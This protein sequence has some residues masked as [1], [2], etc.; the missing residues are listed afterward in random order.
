[1]KGL[2]DTRG[3]HLSGNLD[4][5]P[6]SL[7]VSQERTPYLISSTESYPPEPRYSDN[8]LHPDCLYPLNNQLTNSSTFPRIHFNS[9]YEPPEETPPFP[10]PHAPPAKINRLP[11]SLLDQFEKQLP[12]HRDG[13]STLQF[14]RGAPEGKDRSESPGRI[15]HLVHS[16]QK[17]FAKS[18]SLEGG[19]RASVNGKKGTSDDGKGTRRSKSKERGKGDGK[20]Q[21]RGGGVSGWWSSDD[22]LDSDTGGYRNPAGM[23]T[24]GRRPEHANR[25]F[26]SGYNTIS[27]SMLK[28]SKSNN[29]LKFTPFQP[30]SLTLSPLPTSHDVVP[31]NSTS[32]LKRGSW[33]TLTLSH[34]REV[35]QKASATID[36]ALLKSKS[37]HQDLSYQYLQVPGGEWSGATTKDDDIPCRRMRSGSYIKAMGDADSEDSEGSPQPSPKTAA[38]RQSY[39]KATQQSLSEQSTTQRSLDRVDSLDILSPPNFSNWEEDYNQLTESATEEGSLCQDP[40][41]R[42]LL[43]Y[44]TADAEEQRERY[45]LCQVPEEPRDRYALCQVPEEDIERYTL[46]Q[47]QEEQSERY[48]LCQTVEE[49][50]ERY[51]LCQVPEEQRERYPL[52]QVPEEQRE[53]YPVCQVPEEQRER[54]PLCQV[55]EEQRERYPLC[56]V[57]EEP[58]ERYPLCQVPEEPRERYPL[59]QLPEEQRERYP[60]CQVPEEPMERYSMCQAPEEQRERYP[61]EENRYPLVQAMFGD[62][63]PVRSDAFDLHLPNYFRSRSHSYLRAI[64]AGCSQD[65]D[66]TSLQSMSPPLPITSRTL[67]RHIG[68]SCLVGYKKT[69]PPVPP[70]TTSKPFISVTVQSSTE[71]AQDSYLDAQEGQSEANSQSGLSTSTESL[72]STRA[73]S[74]TRI[75][76]PTPIRQVPPEVPPKNAAVKII[77]EEPRAPDPLPKRKLSSIGIQVDSIQP[78][79]VPEPPPPARFQSIGVQVEEEWRNSRSSSMTSKQETDSDTQEPSNSSDK[80][81]PDCP[82]PRQSTPGPAGLLPKKNLSYGDVEASALPP[83]DPWLDSAASPPSSEPTQVGSCRRDG[84]WFLKL[85]QAETERL[86]GWCKQMQ[87]ETGDNNLCE[88]VIGKVLSAVGSAQLLMSQKFQQFRGLCEQNLNPNSN[89]RPSAQDL[90]GFWDLL[91]LSIEDISMKFDELFQLKA[92]G[93]IL[94]EIPDRNQ[95][96]KR[97]PPPVPKKP[98]RPKPPLSRDK[99]PGTS[100]SDK[101]RQEARKR[102]M[103][104]KRAASVRQN[105]AT[106]S[107]DS[108]EIYVPEAQTRL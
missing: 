41:P 26:L 81:V 38:R 85:L 5:H 94:S 73:P 13:F 61:Q 52:C 78:V 21:P 16:V 59:C 101:Q 77:K 22:N 30:P 24:L 55:P 76:P 65:D 97:P 58:R 96:V 105:S 54:Y 87:R 25:H 14:Q 53:R 19:G 56:Q 29:D 68:S 89:P 57:P 62:S 1:M 79:P 108:I 7:Y 67:P 95:E 83:P 51:P 93:W 99:A 35:C 47:V 9:H 34:A 42:C 48:Q 106:E 49:Q 40:E 23:M 10:T 88:E 84:H 20:G 100:N 8:S 33:S 45:Q 104:A 82:P 66:T 43:Q 107:A 86:E 63:V 4:S 74:V 36:K 70:R 3:R 91:Q 103:A 75:G 27:E 11:A 6:D 17:L 28:A 44:Q 64:Q 80:S 50:R 92:N 2:G 90:A 32:S 12:I 102:L 31:A 46:C 37:C 72:E 15:R 60:L 18:Q 98:A 71:S 69:P 39:L